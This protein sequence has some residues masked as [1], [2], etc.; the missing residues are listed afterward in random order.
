V[1]AQRYRHQPPAETALV[2][3]VQIDQ[4]VLKHGF[5]YVS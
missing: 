4:R 2:D 1:D 3:L 5:T